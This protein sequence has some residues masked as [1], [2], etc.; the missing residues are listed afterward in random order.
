M[1]TDAVNVPMAIGETSIVVLKEAA[2]NTKMFGQGGPERFLNW[3][4]ERLQQ[5]VQTAEVPL[6]WQKGALQL[7][8]PLSEESEKPW[9]SFQYIRFSQCQNKRVSQKNSCGFLPCLCRI[10]AMCRKNHQ[11]QGFSGSLHEVRW[12]ILTT[13]GPGPNAVFPALFGAATLSTLTVSDLWLLKLLSHSSCCTARIFVQWKT[14]NTWS[15]QTLS[16]SSQDSG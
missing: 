8:L 11:T 7:Q 3:P 1:W 15:Q 12:P 16:C 5:A 9:F 14:A 13:S 10:H 6:V 2:T 4:E